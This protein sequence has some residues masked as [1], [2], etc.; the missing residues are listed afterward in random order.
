MIAYFTKK[1]AK[2]T[3]ITLFQV[4]VKPKYTQIYKH[5]SKFTEKCHSQTTPSSKW[6]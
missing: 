2:T 1:L 5:I 4:H 3:I 6:K